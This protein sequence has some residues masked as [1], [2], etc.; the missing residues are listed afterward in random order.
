[1]LIDFGQTFN[2]DDR[3]EPTTY[4]GQQVGNRFLALPEHATTSGNKR[5]L[6]SDLTFCCGILLFTLT[7][8]EPAVLADEQH[9]MPHQ[10][11]AA[12]A[13]LDLLPE[14]TKSRVLNAFD[15]GFQLGLDRRWQSVEALRNHLLTVV[16]PTPGMSS[17][18]AGIERLRARAEAAAGNRAV[19]DALGRVQARVQEAGRD[20][21]RRLGPGYRSEF[22][23]RPP[24]MAGANAW[25][26]C[27]VLAE[28]EGKTISAPF[29]ISVVGTEI[30][31]EELIEFENR[32]TRGRVP[33]ADPDASE[34]PHEDVA[35]AVVGRV[36]AGLGV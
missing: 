31:V 10:R 14:P 6:R 1:M 35:N 7:G 28:L 18:D 9:R 11:E 26:R 5:D 13:A 32:T 27:G 22:E 33:L 12:R 19:L 2:V 24:S 25:I 23:L 20:A 15:V 21:V 36:V 30:V 3:S 8:A 4:A 29:L 16:P 34:S 17:T